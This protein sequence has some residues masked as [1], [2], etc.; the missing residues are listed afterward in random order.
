MVYLKG[1]TAY[2]FK[3][4]ADKT[5]VTFGRGVTAIVGPNGS[6][7]SNITDAI[8]WVLGEQSAR[9]LRGARMEDVI[10]S[11]AENRQ[12]LNYAEVTLKLD[13]A[14]QLIDGAAEIEVTRR[15]YRSGESEYFL[16]HNK[17]RLKDIT[18]LFLDT[19]LGKEAFSI[20]SQG[21]VDE[22]LNA[23][24]EDR[25]QLIEEAAGVLKYKKRKKETESKLSE[26]VGNLARVNDIIFDLEGRVEPLKMEAA[27]ALEYQELLQEM[28]DA[29]IQVTVFD[30]TQL[31]THYSRLEQEIKEYEEMILIKQ[32]KVTRLEQQIGQAA[33]D[34]SLAAA[35]LDK[36]TARLLELT[37]TIERTQGQYHLLA[38]K[39]EN[40]AAS[41]ARLQRELTRLSAESREARQRHDD[42]IKTIDEAKQAVKQLRAEERALEQKLT[43]LNSDVDQL[44]EEARGNYYE[45][46]SEQ[47]A[48]KNELKLIERQLEQ[49]AGYFA[50]HKVDAADRDNYE[51]A[52]KAHRMKQ[53]QLTELEQQLTAAREAYKQEALKVSSLNQ[54]YKTEEE[55][56]FKAY[57]YIEQLTSKH[58]SIVAMQAEF[59]GYFQGVRAVLKDGSLPGIHGAVA[60]LI[61]IDALYQ[62]ALDIALGGQ[63]QSIITED[64]D[65]ART[66][67]AALK[68]KK[69]GRATFLPLTTIKKRELPESVKLQLTEQAGFVGVL[70]D[71]ITTDRRYQAVIQNLTGLTIIADTLPHA[72]QL[73]R[74]VNYKYRIVTLDGNVV[75]P[76]GSMTGGSLNQPSLLLKQKEEER[77]LALKISTYKTS[78]TAL[79]AKVAALKEELAEAEHYGHTLRARGEALAED[80]QEKMLELTQHEQ[81]LAQ[82]QRANEAFAE[83]ADR[84]QEHTELKEQAA[85]LR[86][87]VSRREEEL[88]HIQQ[89]LEDYTVFRTD[90]RTLEKEVSAELNDLRSRRII[91]QERLKYQEEQSAQIQQQQT[92]LEQQTLELTAQN[93]LTSVEEMTA[94]I[95][96]LSTTLADMQHDRTTVQQQLETW[97]S[98]L[99]AQED[100]LSQARHHYNEG[101]RQISGLENGIGEM[102]AR[103][104]RIDV[105]LENLIYHLLE[106]YHMTYEAA[107]AD[108]TDDSDIDAL[109][110][111]VKL[112]KA[113]IEELGPVNIGAIK[114]YE[115]VKERYDFLTEQENDLLAAKA[116]LE[117]VIKEMDSEVMTRFTETFKQVQQHFNV[118]F[119][120]LF[121]GGIGELTLN[122]DDLLTAG[123]DMT[124][125]LPGKKRQQLTLLS[126]GERALTAVALLF[127]ILKVR[128]APFVILDEVEAALDEANVVRFGSYLQTLSDDTQFIVITHRKGT[129]EAADRLYGVTMQNSGIT[130]LVSV[131]LN[132]LDHNKVKELTQ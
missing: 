113:S 37:E 45:T 14:G 54:T 49:L 22:I 15:L 80:R 65:S 12:P 107:A 17:V 21:K 39:K 1:V 32:D 30:I 46:L 78:A 33:A 8:R 28:K 82:L 35:E 87:R 97:R 29:D 50:S 74:I 123:V 44:V 10:F 126:G 99:Q 48:N 69:A 43:A 93:A 67:I 115:E 59:Q 72:N 68:K 4:F 105:Q 60:G 106:D 95:S 108:Y 125:E 25:R 98:E 111:R 73:A 71:L 56:L 31:K 132:E 51:Q 112:T 9:N 62:T 55:N 129:M 7:K 79:E 11:G 16:N 27:I 77:A 26:T 101:M 6:G 19:G 2:G 92:Q 114:Q 110:K 102:K 58:E 52:D 86:Q 96:E 118:V 117:T 81:K 41:T 120:E 84:R 85:D 38:E 83:L 13:E 61:D 18:E 36:L 116:T 90:S 40:H 75:N 91:Q 109:R 3:S 20:I 76:G 64:E 121:G 5:H 104:S 131:N 124:V 53:Q 103:Y 94:K 63:L 128:S 130:Q 119:S 57:R 127:A 122:S 23:K 70:S 47:T 34:K 24:P 42:S 66:A 100:S 89:Q 88:A